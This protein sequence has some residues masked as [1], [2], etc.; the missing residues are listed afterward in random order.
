MVAAIK[1]PALFKNDNEASYIR[2]KTTEK[3]GIL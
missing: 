3:E 2:A 1:V